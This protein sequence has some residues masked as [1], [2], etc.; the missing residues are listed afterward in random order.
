MAYQASHSDNFTY[1]D[2][3]LLKVMAIVDLSILLFG[4]YNCVKYIY[5]KLE[6]KRQV[7]V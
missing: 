2:L 1:N 6:Q 4:L 3:L 7:S 5:T